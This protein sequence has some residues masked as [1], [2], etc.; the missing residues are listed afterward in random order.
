[1]AIEASPDMPR[2]ASSERVRRRTEAGPERVRYEESNG[3]S[4]IRKLNRLV[5]KRVLGGVLVGLLAL[6]FAIGPAV[7]QAAS[8]SPWPTYM[9]GISR[10]GYT[11]DGN[12]TAANA[13]SLAQA[14]S[15]TASPKLQYNSIF[16][17]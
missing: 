15:Y 3:M 6:T 9:N 8:G 10:T 17:Q 14:W 4:L 1:M 2:W 5:G 12:I 11:S 7:A 13:A 16:A